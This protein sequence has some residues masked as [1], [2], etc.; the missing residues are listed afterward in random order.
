MSKNFSS[1]FIVIVEHENTIYA[2]A[3]DD[4]LYAFDLKNG[5]KKWKFEF[6][7]TITAGFTIRNDA[8]RI[9]LATSAPSVFRFFFAKLALKNLAL[10]F[11]FSSKITI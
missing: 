2:T 1:F 5:K 7:D 10:V 11:I 4:C 3:D 9:Y 8:K 6:D